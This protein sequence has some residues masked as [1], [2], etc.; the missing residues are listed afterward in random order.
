MQNILN[1]HIIDIFDNQNFHAIITFIFLKI[2]H[3]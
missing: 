3:G 1:A 2:K